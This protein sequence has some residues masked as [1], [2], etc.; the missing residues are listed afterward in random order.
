MNSTIETTKY[1]FGHVSPE[2]AFEQEGYPWG[3]R[4]RTKIRYWIESKEGYG[5]RFC[6][7]TMNPKTR[8]WCAPKKG[9]YRR[10]VIMF[11]DEN[12]H[13]KNDC[14]YEWDEQKV[15]DF[16]NKHKE[17]FDEFQ[18]EEARYLLAKYLVKSKCKPL[19]FKCSDETNEEL[20]KQESEKFL[21]EANEAQKKI[22]ALI[23]FHAKRWEL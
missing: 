12:N 22:N 11:L 10:I 3:F 7:Q 13:V 5:Q 21:N 20:K 14:I 18:K 17:N 8:L 6:A 23:H 2:T 16:V 4:L 9:T 1:L 15:K 19:K